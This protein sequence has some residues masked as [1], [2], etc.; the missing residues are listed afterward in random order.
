MVYI[1]IHVAVTMM[2]K[3]SKTSK[4]IFSLLIMLPYL[5][6]FFFNK[7]NLSHKK[8]MRN[9]YNIRSIYSRHKFSTQTYVFNS[10]LYI[11][12]HLIILLNVTLYKNST[13]YL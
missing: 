8:L 12:R 7:N 13:M 4:T 9:S 3:L 2:K 5:L 1:K 6:T 10:I 11:S